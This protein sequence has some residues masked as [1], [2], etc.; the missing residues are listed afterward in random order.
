MATRPNVEVFGFAISRPLI[1]QLSPFS[2]SH[3]LKQQIRTP[4]SETY[5]QISISPPSIVPPPSLFRQH[6]IQFG[7]PNCKD[8]YGYE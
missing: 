4:L 7:A 5:R 2:I 1:G 3:W 8:M 6:P